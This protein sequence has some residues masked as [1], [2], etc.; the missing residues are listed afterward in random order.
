MN[1]KEYE[2]KILDYLKSRYPNY[3]ITLDAKL[4][5]RFSKINRQIDV[6]IEQFVANRSI[7]IVFDGKYFSK[8]LDV[9]KVEEFIGFIDDVNATY[10][11]LVTNQG[12]SKAAINRAFYDS[13][14][15]DLEVLN[16]SELESLQAPAGVIY[17][18]RYGI[19]YS[20]PFGWV[21]NEKKE[22]LN[23]QVHL[24]QRGLTL[25]QAMQIP[26]WA[27]LN[28]FPKLKEEEQLSQIHEEYIN[29]IKKNS[30]F[31]ISIETYIREDEKKFILTQSKIKD[32]N[33]LSGMIEFDEIFLQI[34]FICKDEL[35]AKNKT[36]LLEVIS[37]TKKIDPKD[38][39]YLIKSL[40]IYT[41]QIEEANNNNNIEVLK[42]LILA[43]NNAYYQLEMFSELIKESENYINSFGSDLK[44][45]NQ[46]LSLKEYN[47][48]KKIVQIKKI[49]NENIDKP[50]PLMKI[51]HKLYEINDV[52]TSKALDE[53]SIDDTNFCR[54]AIFKYMLGGFYLEKNKPSKAKICLL[55]SYELI[56]KCKE[57]DAFMIKGTLKK[58]LKNKNW[59]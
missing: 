27:Y 48:Q 37:S 19:F 9:K 29:N 12:Y 2:I 10:G 59:L 4:P 50:A 53:I 23:H 58:I 41:S 40:K 24:H 56:D 54:K 36:K 11:I 38:K 44:I 34:V 52:N 49:I 42:D 20:P 6:L 14:N 5:G 18:D 25:S 47:S 30:Y 15:I 35:V 26:E 7:K 31:N 32:K 17:S 33:E 43:R 8:K 55:E 51:L 13:K 22:A 57:D 45:L 1:W 21:V 3:N 16:F 28:T 39:D 46:L